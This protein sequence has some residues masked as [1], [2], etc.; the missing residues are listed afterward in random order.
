MEWSHMFSCTPQTENITLIA[1]NPQITSVFPLFLLS[2]DVSCHCCVYYSVVIFALCFLQVMQWFFNCVWRHTF[3]PLPFACVSSGF[4]QK[5][6]RDTELLCSVNNGCSLCLFL[7]DGLETTFISVGTNL[8]VSHLWEFG[9]VD[10]EK[11]VAVE[12]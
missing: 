11:I 3:S 4:R 7:K 9:N 12:L 8:F 10:P 5:V 6:W 1:P 2:T